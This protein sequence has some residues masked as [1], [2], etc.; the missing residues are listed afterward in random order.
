MQVLP[1]NNAFLDEGLSTNLENE[2]SDSLHCKTVPTATDINDK[3]I[4]DGKSVSC[5]T[6]ND[7]N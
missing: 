5:E 4:V 1:E 6:Q 3:Q 2:F 7:I